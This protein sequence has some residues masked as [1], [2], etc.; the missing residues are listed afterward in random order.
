MGM[1]DEEK[2]NI[3]TE[4]IRSAGFNVHD[5]LTGYLLEGNDMYITRKNNARDLIAT[6]DKNLLRAFV[7]SLEQDGDS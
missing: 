6:L 7:A 5:Q 4:A 1:A 3:I 2:L